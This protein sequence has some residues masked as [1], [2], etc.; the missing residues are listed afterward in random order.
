MNKYLKKVKSVTFNLPPF[1]LLPLDCMIWDSCSL[2]KEVEYFRDFE[3]KNLTYWNYTSNVTSESDAVQPR[4]VTAGIFHS[5]AIIKLFLNA[6]KL[7]EWKHL[8][9]LMCLHIVDPSLQWLKARTNK[10][11]CWYFCFESILPM[12]FKKPSH[13]QEGLRWNSRQKSKLLWHFRKVLLKYPIFPMFLML[14]LQLLYKPYNLVVR[15]WPLHQ[16]IIKRP[17]SSHWLW[18]TDV[19]LNTWLLGNRALHCIPSLKY[20]SYFLYIP[21]SKCVSIQPVCWGAKC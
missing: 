12:S 9:I 10:N 20:L 6:G 21:A 5:T 16:W 7:D 18:L 3:C 14:F 11:I 19:L 13:F 17:S 2:F 15:C 1:V 8:K 4:V